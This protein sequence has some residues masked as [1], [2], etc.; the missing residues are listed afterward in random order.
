MPPLLV[1]FIHARGCKPIC[2]KLL[3]LPVNT[4]RFTT[5]RQ[6]VGKFFCKNQSPADCRGLIRIRNLNLSFGATCTACYYGSNFN[7]NSFKNSLCTAFAWIMSLSIFS[8]SCRTSSRS[9]ISSSGA[10]LT[11]REIFRLY[12][13]F[14]IS[15]IETRREYFLSSSFR[16]W[17]VSMI[18]SI[19]SGKSVF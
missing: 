1:D 3:T 2:A 19:C 10:V 6:V 15:S 4:L 9:I 7:P 5:F 17:Y 11:Y 14:S 18:L 13:F 16:Y 12:P 8:S